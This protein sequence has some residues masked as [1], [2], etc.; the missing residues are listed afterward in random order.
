MSQCLLLMYCF[1][2]VA[3]FAPGV[4]SNNCHLM[5]I[6][7]TTF[8]EYWYRMICYHLDVHTYIHINE[9]KWYVCV[10]DWLWWY[11]V[12]MYPSHVFA[13][14]DSLPRQM[15]GFIDSSENDSRAMLYGHRQVMRIMR[16]IA[17]DDRDHF[18]LFMSRCFFLCM[19]TSYIVFGGQIINETESNMFFTT[20]LFISSM[21]GFLL[22][23]KHTPFCHMFSSKQPN[24]TFPINKKQQHPSSKLWRA[25]IDAY[26][27]FYQ[28]WHS[29]GL[30]DSVEPSGA[31]RWSQQIC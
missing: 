21:S 22:F 16:K 20:C 15:Y 27:C 6:N 10:S 18:S 17:V 7:P 26:G 2:N 25:T 14:F 8:A 3:D 31:A 5:P 29:C 24:V 19:S 28:A 30:G 12:N 4:F 23:Y 13:A 1:I 9:Y 11:C